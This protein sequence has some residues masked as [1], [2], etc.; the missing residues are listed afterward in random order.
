MT[1]GVPLVPRYEDENLPAPMD[2][3]APMPAAS[4]GDNDDDGGGFGK[5]LLLPRRPEDAITTQDYLASLGKEDPG[6]TPLIRHLQSRPN[7]VEMRPSRHFHPTQ[8]AK[9]PPDK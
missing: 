8:A 7:P 4:G 3:S 1:T 5:A 2:H 6:V 9:A